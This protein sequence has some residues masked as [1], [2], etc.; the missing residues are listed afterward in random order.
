MPQQ[1]TSA[2][3]TCHFGPLDND[4]A[5][6]AKHR[7][8]WHPTDTR[9]HLWD[10]VGTIR[11]R[12][13]PFCASRNQLTPCGTTH[14]RSI[15]LFMLEYLWKAS[16]NHRA[17]YTLR[18]VTRYTTT[19]VHTSTT[20]ELKQNINNSTNI[21]TNTAASVTHIITTPTLH[22]SPAITTANTTNKNRTEPNTA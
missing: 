1:T 21:C 2:H 10:P 3:T 17:A 7:T 22:T 8:H 6:G 18:L 20:L 13:A 5:L 4:W 15:S 11:H 12:W 19:P 14:R 9:R 16:Q